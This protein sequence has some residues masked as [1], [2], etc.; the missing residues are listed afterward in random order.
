MS[1]CLHLNLLGSPTPG[2]LRTFTNM[3][4]LGTHIHGATETH[5]STV[6]YPS[7]LRDNAKFLEEGFLW[8]FQTHTHAHTVTNLLYCL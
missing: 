3:L 4:Q 2:W 1:K 6:H 7:V 5:S 8:L